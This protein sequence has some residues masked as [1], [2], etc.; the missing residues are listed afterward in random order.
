MGRLL[1]V[2][3]DTEILKILERRL[4]KN[5]NEIITESNWKEALRKAHTV[6]VALVDQRMPDISGTELMEKLKKVNPELEVVIMTAYGS[7]E[8]A[9]E[10]IKRGAFHYVTKPINFEELTNILKKAYELKKTRERLANLESILELDIV[11]ESPRMREVIS[12]AKK[13]APFDI[14][15]LIT[16]ESGV[17]K[18]VIARFIHRMSRRREKSFIPVN[19]ASIPEN[20]LEAELF[21]YKKGSFSGAYA[22]RKGLVEE[23]EG[24]TLFLDEIG[25]MPLPLQAKILRLLQEGEIKPLGESRPKKVNVRVIC[26]TN[27]DIKRLIEEGKFRED[28]YFRINVIH[29]HIPPLR[30]RKEDIIPLAYHF[31]KRASHKFGVEP[32]E[33]SEKAKK[34]LLSYDWPGNVREL[35]NTIERSF[36]LNEGRVIEKIYFGEES[37]SISDTYIKP[38]KEAREEFEKNYL[39]KLLD[40]C[41]WN[42]TKASKLS[43]KTRAEIYRLMKKYGLK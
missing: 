40:V 32:K 37:V 13:V 42:I 21:G 23:A 12:V 28:L 24:G 43:G 35:S 31:I 15:V 18:E 5:F 8:D 29:I 14:P 10:S 9:V 11:A 34:E 20:L 17:G 19:C 30:E 26:A 2:D 3:D 1:I 33:L 27:K 22:D 41:N 6:D 36:I 16:G 38:Y 7:I 39:L 25:D 4:R